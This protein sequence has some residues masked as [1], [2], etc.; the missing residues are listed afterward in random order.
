MTDAKLTLTRGPF[1]VDGVPIGVVAVPGFG[2]RVVKL[3]PPKTPAEEPKLGRVSTCFHGVGLR[4]AYV[5][6]ATKDKTTDE[7]LCRLCVFERDRLK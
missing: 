4:P 6:G 2:R 7:D 1:W 3:T 5:K